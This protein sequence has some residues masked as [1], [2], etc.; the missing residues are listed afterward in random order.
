MRTYFSTLP[1]PVR[2]EELIVVGDRIFTDV[3]LANRMARVLPAHHEAGSAANEKDN[4]IP[5]P[6]IDASTPPNSM[7]SMSKV[8]MR[9]GPLSIWT[10]SVWEKESMLMRALER[11]F[12]QGIQKYVVPDNGVRH[13]GDVEQFVK[14]GPVLA[15]PEMKPSLARRVWETVRRA[16]RGNKD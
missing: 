5:A 2:D 10:T 14:E 1:E 3:V 7:S 9:T 11:G 6:S 12:M 8:K 15:A 4:R 13:L 16:R